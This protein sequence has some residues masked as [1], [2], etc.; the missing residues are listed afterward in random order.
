MSGTAPQPSR[1][2][3][4]PETDDAG[5]DFPDLRRRGARGGWWLLVVV[6]VAVVVLLVTQPWAG[7]EPVPVPTPS[8]VPDAPTP[9]TEPS[10]DPSASSTAAPAPGAGAVFD[11]ATAPSLFVTA[12]DLENDVPAGA[13]VTRSVEPGTSAWGLPAGT[14]VDPSSCTA[15][16]TVLEAPPSV[17][18]A[19]SWANDELRFQQDVVLLPDAQTAREAFRALVTVVDE[20]PR[21]ALVDAAGDGTTWTAEPALEGQSVFPA[22]V[23]DVTAQTAG[24]TTQQTTGHV[25]VGN[26]ILTW[27]ATALTAG[28]REAA[29]AVVGQPED[30][31]VMVEERALAAVRALT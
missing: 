5:D 10:A 21:Y 17:Y 19:T 1:A 11:A 29:R 6:V 20:C 8:V 24:D 18:D 26:A 13:G 22:I 23:Q 27:T 14:S 25:L 2:P 9:E 12:T 4:T 3:G 28:D 16:V 7:D 31:T 15:A 30:L